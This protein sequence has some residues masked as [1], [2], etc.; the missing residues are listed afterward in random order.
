MVY[1]KPP[2]GR[3]YS[4]APT[5]G[6]GGDNQRGGGVNGGWGVGW[7]VELKSNDSNGG[8]GL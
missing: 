6:G 8:G 4:S 5:G 1:T 2:Q 3:I 7:T